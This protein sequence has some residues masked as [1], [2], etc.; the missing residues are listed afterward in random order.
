[1]NLNAFMEG[2]Y[3][4]QFPKKIIF[5]IGSSRDI[6]LEAKALGGS[7]VLLITDKN[8][9]QLNIIRDVERN[10]LTE[11]LD[12]EIFSDVEAEPS[13]E[14]AERIAEFA[15]NGEYNLVIGVGGGSV[16]DMAKVASIAVTNSGPM[17][18]YVGVNLVVKPGLPKILMPTTAGTGS[19]VT[20]VAV[21]T[22][23]DEEAKSA[24]ISPYM[25]S[26]IAIVDPKLTYTMPKKI[27]AS[28]GLDALSHA[29]EALMAVNASPLT[30]SL[31]LQSIRIIVKCLP[32][33]Y[34][35]GDVKSRF[36]MS[37]GSLMAG[38]AFAN[39]WVCLGHALAYSFSVT[40]KI[41][42]GISCGLSLPYAFKFNTPVIQ[43]KIQ[44]IAEAMDITRDTKTKSPED[45][46][47]L[48]FNKLLNLLDDLNM[49]KRLRDIGIPKDD[50]DKIAS[51]LL[52]FTRLIQRNPR[53]VSKDNARELIA[54]MWRGYN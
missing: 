27:T 49:P 45:L 37:L 9:M 1:M 38:I 50:V 23:L 15:R 14:M 34:K 51:K 25:I 41:P 52:T 16:L 31:A 39:S 4:F 10:L 33:A 43:H 11:N 44:H 19:E 54:E 13:I 21:I 36:G 2:I 22:L 6:G 26:D 46:G 20:S 42:H 8:L 17:R 30:D 18:K 5:G 48:I 53:E 28:T 12:V 3:N 32:D 24:I 40:Y 35:T 29:L 47:K 7:E